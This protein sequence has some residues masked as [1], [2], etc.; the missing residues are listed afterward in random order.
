MLTNKSLPLISIVIPTYNNSTYLKKSLKSVLDQ[1][2]KNWETIV[3]DNCS[4]DDT[5]TVVKKFNDQR[6][7]Y[8]KIHN[9]GIIAKS[10]NLGVY[11]AKGE[12]IAFLDSDDWW[13]KDKLKICLHY[14]N[15]QVDLIYHDLEI[16]SS[17]QKLLKK[18]LIKTRKLKKPILKDLLIN[19]NAISNSSVIVRKKII[20]KIGFIDESENLVAAEDYNLWLKISNFTEKFLY[21]PKTLGYYSVHDENISNKDMSSPTRIAVNEFLSVLNNNQKIRL[22]A[23][24]QYISARFNF[25]KTNYNGLKK[26]LLFVIKYGSVKYKLRALI[27]LLKIFINLRIKS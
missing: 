11:T 25:L 15:N 8:L 26:N 22:E 4:N 2:Y 5:Y 6:I 3:I 21:I 23:N 13:T 20:E 27:M 14:L 10:R 7:K 24:L 1:T 12:W 18:K 9:N 17:K 16:S 19:G